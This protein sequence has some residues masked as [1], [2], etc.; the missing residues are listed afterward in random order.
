[1][2]NILN[3]M[4]YIKDRI[5][6]N[7]LKL[8]LPFN[9]DQATKIDPHTHIYV[10]SYNGNSKKEKYNFPRPLLLKKPV[11]LGIGKCMLFLL[12]LCTEIAE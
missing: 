12:N 7:W 8:W 2:V 11:G 3:T 1:M 5:I 6:A 4:F 9:I 10:V